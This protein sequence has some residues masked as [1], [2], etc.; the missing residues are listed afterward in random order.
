MSA[1]ARPDFWLS[2]GYRLLRRSGAGRL[3]ITDDFLRAYFGRPEMLPAADSSQAEHTLHA[4]LAAHPRHA[5]AEEALDALADP[6]LRD[7]YRHLLRFRDRLLAAGTLEAAYLRLFRGGGIDIPPLFVDHLT[8]AILRNLLDDCDDPFAARA[9]ELLF[10]SQKVSMQDGAILLAD[11]ETV[12]RYAATGGLGTLGMLLG[13]A[14]KSP[15]RVSLDVLGSDNAALYWERSDR[16]DTVLDL[17]FGHR[18]SDAFCRVL[19]RWIG[20]LL[21]VTVHIEPVQ[22]IRDD[23]WRWHVGLDSESSSLLN[24]LYRGLAIAD[25]RLARMLALFRLTFADPAVMRTE[26]AG[27]PVY[28]GL[29]MTPGLR[30]RLKPQNLIGNLPLARTG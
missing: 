8:H 27:R 3:E 16:F 1:A 20:H 29:A 15:G 19:E 30:L 14:K 23:H 2:S 9:G 11:E 12:D 22:A 28:L 5:V 21:G 6:D 25:D 7:N 18:G 17:S 4:L 24:D 13:D 26:L 10:R